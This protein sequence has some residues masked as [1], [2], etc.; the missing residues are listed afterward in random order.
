[1]TRFIATS[2]FDLCGSIPRFI[3]D[4]LTTPGAARAP[5][6]A[7][8]YFNQIKSAESFEAADG[9]ELGQLLVLDLNDVRNKRD[10]HPLEAKLKTFVERTAALRGV[11]DA[12]PWF[13]ALLVEAL[14][15]RLRVPKGCDKALAEM[16]EGDA[17]KAGRAFANAL[18]A[19]VSAEA[20]V[21]EWAKT[22]PALGGLEQ[23]CVHAN[24]SVCCAKCF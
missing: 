16:T 5:L 10:P 11:Q 19:N 9:K 2:T 13:E 3:S 6:A 12:H 7:L 14:R 22:Y 8:R 20:A 21:D 17:R 4:S 23:R 15:N 1:V 18:V 24:P